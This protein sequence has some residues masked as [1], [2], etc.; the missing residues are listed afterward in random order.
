MQQ[1][2]I[3]IVDDHVL[4]REGWNL[5]LNSDKRFKVIAECGSAESANDTVRLTRPD[6]VLL[7]INLP[8]MNGVEAVPIIKKISPDTKILGVSL[9]ASPAYAKK[10]MGQGG[11]GYLTKNS[12]KEEMIEAILKIYKGEKFICREIK[13]L[14]SANLFEENEPSS[15]LNLLSP[16][17]LEIISLIKKGM[18]SKEIAEK[19]H[20]V[21]KTVEVHR[22]NILKKLQLKNSASLVNFISKH[23]PEI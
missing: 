9:H 21:V 23:Y 19:L 2:R 22:F 7:D 13:D 3:I 20:I 4:V 1:I 6:V 14:V 10:F 17:E 16:R 15:K 18:T 11:N 5:L 8:G 12:P